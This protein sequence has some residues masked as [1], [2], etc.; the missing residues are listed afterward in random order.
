[1]MQN[2]TGKPELMKKMNLTL[3]YRALIEMQSATRAEIS[4]RTK[5]STTTVR[6]LLEELL[7]SGEIVELQLDESSGGRRAQRYSLNL[8]RN[9]I[10]SFFLDGKNIIYQVSDLIGNVLKSDCHETNGEKLSVS[11]FVAKCLKKWKICAV[12]IGVPGIV[13]NEHYYVSTG[14]NLWYINNLGEQIQTTYHLPVILENDLNAIAFGFAIHYAKKNRDCDL[15]TINMAYIHVNKNCSGAG[16][17][18]DG[19]IVHGAKRFAGELG[20]LPLLPNKDV[21]TV[22]EESADK[23]EITNSIA[24]LISIVNCVT[25]PSL[26]VI[27]GERFQIDHIS[28]EEIKASVQTYISD[29]MQPEIIFSGNFK[30][31][32]L[33]GLTCLTAQT[34]I[35]R[36]PVSKD[37]QEE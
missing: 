22:L 33:T 14:F 3:V 21:D 35:P 27:G 34:V 7:Q 5:I 28:L 9:L 20:F 18:V 24:R 23:Q 13:E 6:T 10:L 25:N 1:M 16:I 19:K 32:Y 12:G 30:N 4:E 36:L 15:S 31:D 2:I 26:V 17:I 11:Q 8:K 37:I 29:I